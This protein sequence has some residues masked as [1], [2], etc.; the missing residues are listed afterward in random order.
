MAVVVVMVMV[1]VAASA[2]A[3][4]PGRHA[5]HGGGAAVGS[6]CLFTNASGNF[7]RWVLFLISP[8][9]LRVRPRR[10]TRI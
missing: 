1:R 8:A 10:R 5:R 4:V 9:H 6:P 7:L 2:A 3:E